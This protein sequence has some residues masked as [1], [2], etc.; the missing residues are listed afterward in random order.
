MMKDAPA[1][2]SQLHNLASTIAYRGSLLHGVCHILIRACVICIFR[3][4]VTRDGLIHIVQAA[5]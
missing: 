2:C 4:Q 3:E 5:L 1:Q